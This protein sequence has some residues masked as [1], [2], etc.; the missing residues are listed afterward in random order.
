MLEMI[1]N[2]SDVD[3]LLDP[4]PF[5]SD[6][7]VHNNGLPATGRG[8]VK[9]LSGS[10]GNLELFVRFV[11]TN[12]FFV[13]E[14]ILSLRFPSEIPSIAPLGPFCNPKRSMHKLEAMNVAKPRT[15][16]C[17]PSKFPLIL[18]KFKIEHALNSIDFL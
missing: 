3:S 2:F 17:L 12:F 18:V 1:F 6:M 13:S 7:N 5:V 8:C 16:A 10:H 4:S 14:I 15:N 9:R 11:Y